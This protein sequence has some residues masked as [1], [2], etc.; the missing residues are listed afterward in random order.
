MRGGRRVYVC[1]EMDEPIGVQGRCQRLF[2]REQ[3]T[4]REYFWSWNALKPGETVAAE[5]LCDVDRRV[6]RVVIDQ[7][8]LDP[9][10]SEV[11][12]ASFTKRSA[13]CVAR[14]ATT[15]I[16]STRVPST[17]TSLPVLPDR[18]V[19]MIS[20][21]IVTRGNVD[22]SPILDSLTFDDVVVWKT[23]SAKTCP[24][25]AAIRDLRDAAN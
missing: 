4:Q 21:V 22:L 5:A 19:G 20:A 7:V 9:V 15:R 25:M 1:V 16:L 23:W 10:S 8:R 2:S 13:L 12:D 17:A 14:R 6:R 3:S 11:L 24:C 18:G